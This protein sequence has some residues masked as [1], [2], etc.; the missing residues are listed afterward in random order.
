VP[1]PPR[2]GNCARR[3]VAV[4][5]R[6]DDAAAAAREGAGTSFQFKGNEPI[7]EAEARKAKE[8][9]RKGRRTK[10]EG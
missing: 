6:N 8:G 1:W 10:D 2:R 4:D 9:R 3:R 7:I 5:L